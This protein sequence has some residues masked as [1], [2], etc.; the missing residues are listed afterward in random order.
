M[1]NGKLVLYALRN[2]AEQLRRVH[3]V[4]VVDM[5]V[6]GVNGLYTV[7]VKVEN[8]KGRMD[9]ATGAVSVENLRGDDL[10]NAL[11]KA[12]TKAKRRATLSLCGLGMLDETEIETV[13]GAQTVAPEVLHD[14]QPPPTRADPQPPAEQAARP[15]TS[16]QEFYRQPKDED[17][18]Q[19]PVT[20]EEKLAAIQKVKDLM[21]SR[22][23]CAIDDAMA[24]S[25]IGRVV[26]HLHRKS[27]VET[28]GELATV[29]E[30]LDVGRYTLESGEFIP[31]PKEEGEAT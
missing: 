15:K 22:E 16:A 2:C 20:H 30:A 7:T 24:T 17:P 21:Q 13:A 4:S 14:E 5:R 8:A 12:E 9:M 28:S 31:P 18:T 3:G 23:H 26:K 10:A 6:E 27:Y 29:I 25:I 19:A 11:M 1:V